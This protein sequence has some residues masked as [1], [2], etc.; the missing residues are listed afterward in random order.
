MISVFLG[1]PVLDFFCFEMELSDTKIM[2]QPCKFES[3]VKR[4][5]IYRNFQIS[6]RQ[7]NPQMFSNFDNS[8]NFNGFLSSLFDF[9]SQCKKN[10]EEID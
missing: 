7:S 5:P 8:K 6:Q 9:C 1:E 3:D 2:L 10:G 4:V